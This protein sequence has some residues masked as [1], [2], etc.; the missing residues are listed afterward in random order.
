MYSFG[1]PQTIVSD[2]ATCFTASA[3]YSSMAHHGITWCT[4]LTY[5]PMSNGR[6]ERMVGTLK[7]AVRDTVLETGMESWTKHSLRSNMDIADAP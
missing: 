2:S 6:A 4:V 5:A 3:V 1:P 7:P